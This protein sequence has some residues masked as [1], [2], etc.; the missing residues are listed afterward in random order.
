MG[1]KWTCEMLCIYNEWYVVEVLHDYDM[2][3]I[4]HDDC[5]QLGTSKY[6]ENCA[7]IL[8]EISASLR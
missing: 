3:I 6:K 2:S 8:T 1:K 4:V 7:K 5:R